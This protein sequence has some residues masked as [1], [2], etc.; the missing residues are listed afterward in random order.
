MDA[1]RLP[2][3]DGDPRDPRGLRVAVLC[4][5][6]CPLGTLGTRT[7]GG[8]SVYV[9]EIAESLGRMGHALDLYTGVADEGHPE[10][11]DVA[12]GV[13]LVH[14]CPPGGRAPVSR[15]E[16]LARMDGYA[17]ALEDLRSREGRGYDLVHSHY[18]LSGLLGERV[19]RAWRV[20][21]VLMFHTL[22]SVKNLSLPGPREPAVRLEAERGLARSCTRVLAGTDAEKRRIARES[23]VPPG[24]IGR[25]SC[26]VN[27]ERFPLWPRAEARDRLGL[28][29]AERVL[30]F[31]GRFD[32][33][34]GI[35]RLV[36]A[37]AERAVPAD[38]RLVLVGGDGPGSPET[39]RLE[40]LAREQGVDGRVRFAGRAAREL[41]AAHYAAADALVLPSASESFGLVAL[42]ALACGTPVLATPV[43]VMEPL[44][45]DGFRGRLVRDASPA[46]LAGSIGAFLEHLR[47][48]PRAP[49]ALRDSVRSFCWQDAARQVLR[50]Y[51]RALAPPR[52]ACGHAAHERT[53]G[54]P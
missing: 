16:V 32:A 2:G 28:A 36:A 46:G 21:H 3:K 53:G 8:M 17:A 31:V 54:L 45:R 20:P 7:N 14:L 26:G 49:R 38:A 15:E 1:V 5:H 48:H 41:L 22:G 19:S 44:L 33:I 39:Q 52:D 51:G 12:P 24:K 29:A 40:R 9:R 37:M 18:W 30:L 11:M 50:E 27:L 42:E 34:K 43:G 35:D 4:L 23:G 25:V 47:E 13:R 10:E 6:A